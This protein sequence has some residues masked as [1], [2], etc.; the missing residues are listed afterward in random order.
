VEYRLFGEANY[1]EKGA[2]I[3]TNLVYLRLGGVTTL[4]RHLSFIFRPFGARSPATKDPRL[5]PWAVFF[6]PLRG[7]LGAFPGLLERG[8]EPIFQRRRY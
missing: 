5:A 6:S 8:Y 1:A 3:V 4:V 2:P 7:F